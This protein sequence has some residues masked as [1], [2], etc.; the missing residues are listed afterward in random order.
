M[1]LDEKDFNS[2]DPKVPFPKMPARGCDDYG[3]LILKEVGQGE[4]V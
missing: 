3:G 2:S 1:A 4:G